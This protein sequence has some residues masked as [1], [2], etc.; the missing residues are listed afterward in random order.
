MDGY[1]LCLVENADD[2]A[3]YHRIRRTVLFEARGRFDYVT[4]G[5]E[6]L[7]AEN[8]SLLLKYREQPIGTVRL[9]Q[10]PNGKAIVRL[11]ATI[12][13]LQKQGHGTAIIQRVE[14]LAAS[15]G[16]NQLLVHAA[17]DAVDFYQKL[18]FSRFDFDTADIQSVQ[19]RKLI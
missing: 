3:A 17:L 1:E 18:G 15:L 19:L 2:W 5:P 9:D 8:L 12:S 16:F 6:E 11:V 10:K 13:H 7:K 14:I 4:D